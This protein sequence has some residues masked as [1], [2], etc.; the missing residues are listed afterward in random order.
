MI[1]IG[2]STCNGKLLFLTGKP[3]SDFAGHKGGNERRMPWK[4]CKLPFLTWQGHRIGLTFEKDFF[5]R[6]D[7]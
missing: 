7:F 1:H 2:N 5:S 6:Y 3:V 4:H